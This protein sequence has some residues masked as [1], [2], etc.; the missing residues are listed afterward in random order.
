VTLPSTCERNFT[1]TSNA[2][3]SVVS[4]ALAGVAVDPQILHGHE[5]L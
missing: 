1:P 2:E 4:A 5:A 3:L